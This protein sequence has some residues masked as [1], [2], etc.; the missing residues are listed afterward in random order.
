MS[1]PLRLEEHGGPSPTDQGGITMGNQ[2]ERQRLRLAKRLVLTPISG[3]ARRWALSGVASASKR[4]TLRHVV[5]PGLAASRRPF[6]RHVGSDLVFRG[7][8]EDF[9]PVMISI[10]GEWEPVLTE[11]LRR[12][13]TPG[14]VFVDVGAN[15]GWFTSVASRWVGPSGSVV[16]I[17]AS[18]PLFE[19]LKAQVD[20]NHLENVR[21]VNQAVGASSGWARIQA[22]PSAHTGLTR[23]VPANSPA[24]DEVV[25]RTLPSI[26]TEQEISRC[27]AIKIDVEGS[28]YN[29]IR[30]M[31]EMLSALP[32]DAEIVVE[33]G[34][35][36]A[37]LPSEVAEL[38]DTFRVHGYHAYTLP[39][40]YSVATYRDPIYPS[41]LERLRHLPD[42]ET[43]VVFSRTDAARLPF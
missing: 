3:V 37:I 24:A 13:L 20:R 40:V 38:F 14:R 32:T 9:L 33:V 12:R 34:P 41:A 6:E 11:F 36:R 28:E 8:S 16:A 30:G 25:V 35:E 17:E 29:V 19:Q 10:F 23:V 42:R 43:D 26:L 5:L 27:R 39:N 2:I 1:P 4:F 15:L 7:N 31:Q 21:A 18:P 22:G